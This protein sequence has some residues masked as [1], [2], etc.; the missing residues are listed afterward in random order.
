MNTQNNSLSID[1]FKTAILRACRGIETNHDYLTE[2]DQ[3]IGDG[4]LG[5]T[6]KKIAL[7]LREYVTTAQGEDIGQF[8]VGAGLV[9]NRVGS[10]SFGTLTS[11]ALMRAGMKV[12]GNN[13]ISIDSLPEILFAATFGIQERGKAQLNDKTVLDVLLPACDALKSSLDSGV[14]LKDANIKMVEAARRGRD[15]VTPLKSLIGRA[16]WLG[17][18]TKG[19]IDP[20]CAVAVI[21]LEAITNNTKTGIL[22]YK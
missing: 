20:G 8:L 3:A 11:T 14:S 21:I 4:D 1:S 5:I 12:K 6:M 22:R 7:A 17:E 19:K 18:Q 13:Q 10:S 9:A 16:S 2:L 15:H